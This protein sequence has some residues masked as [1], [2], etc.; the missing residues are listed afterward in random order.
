MISFRT[1]SEDDRGRIVGVRAGVDAYFDTRV[2]RDKAGR[3][4]WFVVE[5]R[6]GEV[7]GWVILHW[8]TE[9]DLP[10]IEDLYVIESRRG[11]G[12]GTELLAEAE[13]LAQEAGATTMRL[14]VNPTENAKA[15]RLYERLGYSD[16]GS[17]S[18]LDG[19]YDGN[20][21][22]V[23]DMTKRLANYN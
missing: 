11:E 19:V 22:W 17:P 16:D 4:R 3:T 18:Y 8:G 7:L 10:C 9:S 21:D 12:L 5:E 14:A 1:V 2:E 20:E 23:V 13:R 15:R 6:G